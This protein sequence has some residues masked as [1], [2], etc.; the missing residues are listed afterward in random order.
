M[1]LDI[2]A[3]KG[4]EK[5][6]CVFDEDG[7]PLN[8][9]TRE[10]LDY[11]DDYVTQAFINSDYPERAE[12]VVH[13]GVYRA[14]DSMGFRAGSYSGYNGWREDLAKLAGYPATAFTAYGRTTH[15]HDAGAWAASEGPFW[16]LICF[17]DCEGVIG[18]VVSAKLARD[19]AEWDERAKA[20][21]EGPSWFYERFQ[22]WRAAFEMAADSGMVNFH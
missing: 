15:R 1:G 16:E 20:Y 13:K 10:A 5:V 3:Y 22:E 11:G 21:S 19:F 2:T 4:I 6:D 12:G 18:P 7:Q 8:P 14:K 9:I 17:S